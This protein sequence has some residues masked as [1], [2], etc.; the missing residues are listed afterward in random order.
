M[1]NK[2]IF[3]IGQQHAGRDIYNIAGDLNI[4]Q[5]SP[6]EDVLKVIQAIQHKVGEL[7]IEEKGKRKIRNY[8]DN[9]ICELEDKEP[10]KKSI[11]ESIKQ[12]NEILK[13]A[14]TTGKTLK[15]IGIL[16]GKTATWLGTT[17]VKLGWT[18]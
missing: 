4:N 9:V 6:A 10:N 18:L 1:N 7:D 15:D 13:E 12:T 11:V 5:N 2:S 17:A 14:K 16:I 8:L 3:S